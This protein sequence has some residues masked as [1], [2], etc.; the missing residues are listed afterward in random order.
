M[1]VYGKD[2]DRSELPRLAI[3]PYPS[4]YEKQLA[5]DDGTEIKIRPIRPEDEP[6]L[7]NFHHT[8]VGAQRVPA[9]LPLDETRAAHRA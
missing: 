7:V 6:L 1:V 2:T 4:R 8:L 9:L 3:R 5:L